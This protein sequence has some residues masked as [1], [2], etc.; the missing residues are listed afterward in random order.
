MFC[1]TEINPKDYP[2][3]QYLWHP[4]DSTTQPTRFI[5]TRLM[6]GV[7]PSPFLAMN[8]IKHHI[9]QPDMQNHFPEACEVA[10]SLYVDDLCSGGSDDAEVI[11][12]A[13][14]LI[15]LFQLG[16][17]KFTKFV[18]NSQAVMDIIQEED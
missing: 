15:E 16:G 11:K 8:T 4:Y 1:Q 9:S 17:W 2:F 12:L 18:S 13:T 5:M 10:K 7:K 6:F 14:Q 3:Q